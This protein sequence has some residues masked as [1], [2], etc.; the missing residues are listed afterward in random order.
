MGSSRRRRQPPRSVQLLLQP[1]L[2]RWFKL[3]LGLQ[4]GR[5]KKELRLLSVLGLWEDWEGPP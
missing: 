1:R 5:E 4:W 2:R 3:G